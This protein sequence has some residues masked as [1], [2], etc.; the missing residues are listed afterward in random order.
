VSCFAL[1][2]VLTSLV[3]VSPVVAA[4]AFVVLSGSAHLLWRMLV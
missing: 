4:S 1:L 3:V 2:C